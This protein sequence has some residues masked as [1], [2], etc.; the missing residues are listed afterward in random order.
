MN[1]L[2][3]MA[4]AFVGW[5]A[6]AGTE[7]L[8]VPEVKK[9]KDS[10]AQETLYGA[11]PAPK[12]QGFVSFEDIR[13]MV[14]KVNIPVPLSLTLPGQA[15]LKGQVH[16]YRREMENA[17][18]E[19]AVD[20]F[21]V[22]KAE[23]GGKTIWRHMTGIKKKNS[24]ALHDEIRQAFY[25]EALNLLIA[26]TPPLGKK[27]QRGLSA[28]ELAREK[29]HRPL[30]W[31]FLKHNR[32]QSRFELDTKDKD[33]F[34]GRQINLIPLETHPVAQ[35]VL[36]EDPSALYSAV[37]SVLSGPAKDFLS[38][39]HSR[40]KDQKT[41][42]HLFAEV[43][44]HQK[45]IAQALDVLVNFS[46]PNRVNFV[47]REHDVQFMDVVAQGFGLSSLF[48]GLPSSAHFFSSGQVG[49]GA[50]AFLLSAVG[51]GLCERSF[52]SNKTVDPIIKSRRL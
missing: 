39:L 8:Q 5:T 40:T 1:K 41:L 19:S 25:E 22:V 9:I 28:W 4:L 2:F 35:A 24:S 44:S 51:L 20:F 3:V 18:Q 30:A 37:W 27:D 12:E 23:D 42:F 17:L 52:R 14:D 21:R 26:I 31:V 36:R 11:E 43:K 32:I 46:V 49:A 13:L 29:G 48:L 15:I 6:F 50:F 34:W 38:L 16:A 7:D 45:E 47:K 10:K 33:D